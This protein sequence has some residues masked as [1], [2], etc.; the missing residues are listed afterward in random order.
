MLPFPD[1]RPATPGPA[2]GRPALVMSHSFGFARREW[3]EVGGLLADQY[4]TVAIDMPGFGAAHD[5]TGYAMADIARQFAEVINA[6]ALDRYV[7]VGHSMTGRVMS[8]LA[9][10]VGPTLGLA[11]GPEK[12]VLVTPTPLGQ[13]VGSEEMRQ[14]LLAAQANRWDAEKYVAT[15]TGLPLGP[16][17]KERTM[18]DYLQASRPAWEAWLNAGIREDWVDRAAP[19]AVETLVIAAERDPIWGA[20]TQHKFTMPHLTNARLVTV[21]SGH[22]VPLELP[23]RLAELLADFVGH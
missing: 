7:L 16:D 20:D 5:V 8:I 9:S 3:I 15:H 6:L 18:Q 12:L 19:I 21:D 4:R 23:A 13:E 11:R 17:V 1:M 2:D 14:M 10:R 22:L